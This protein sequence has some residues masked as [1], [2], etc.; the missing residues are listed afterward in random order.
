MEARRNP[1]WKSRTVTEKKVKVVCG[2]Y[3]TTFDGQAVFKRFGSDSIERATRVL[4]RLQKTSCHCVPSRVI[5]RPRMPNDIDKH[6]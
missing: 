1:A 3:R 5:A 2:F 4:I 6:R